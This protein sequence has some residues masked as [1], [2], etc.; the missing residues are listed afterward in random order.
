MLVE[1][2][3]GY[4]RWHLDAFHAGAGCGRSSAMSRK[5][6]WN[7]CRKRRASKLNTQGVEESL[8]L[9]WE[10]ESGKW[11]SWGISPQLEPRREVM[12]C[13]SQQPDPV[14]APLAARFYWIVYRLLREDSS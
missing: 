10:L 6:P 1:G 13:R 11:S 12:P 8:N 4:F 3:I 9:R 7:I 5:I 2:L 14:G